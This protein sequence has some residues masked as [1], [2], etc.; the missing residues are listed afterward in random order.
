[1]ETVVTERR[2][3]RRLDPQEASW[4]S[5][6][7]RTGHP[8]TLLDIGAGGAL[9]ES[10]ARLLPGKPVDL[11]LTGPEL[12]LNLRAVVVRCSVCALDSDHGVRYRGALAFVDPIEEPAGARRAG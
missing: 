5:A 4:Q 10:R 9:V 8:L 11:Q 1:V 3:S 6:R 12:S 2:R 7:L